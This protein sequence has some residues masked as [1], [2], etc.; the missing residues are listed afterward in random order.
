MNEGQFAALSDEQ[1]NKITH[2][3]AMR[4]FSFNP[5]AT[6][7]REYCTAKALRAEA[8]DVDT[9]THVGRPPDARGS[10]LLQDLYSQSGYGDTGASDLS[11][12]PPMRCRTD[13]IELT[14]GEPYLVAKCRTIVGAT[15]VTRPD[16]RVL[17]QCRRR[18]PRTR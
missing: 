17:H 10:R 13:R 5:F 9:V 12:D 7:P 6:R 14:L 4:H 18:S 11:S 8:L 1:I 3:N 15:L 2:L 16:P